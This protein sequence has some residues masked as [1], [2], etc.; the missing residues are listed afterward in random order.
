MVSK[1][2]RIFFTVNPLSTEGL[3]K[4]L[5]PSSS[6]CSVQQKERLYVFLH[7][8]L[9]LKFY[10]QLLTTQS[11]WTLPN[12]GPLLSEEERK[13]KKKKQRA[14]QGQRFHACLAFFVVMVSCCKCGTKWTWHMSP[15][16]LSKCLL[17]C[18]SSW[19]SSSIHTLF[20]LL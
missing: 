3:K 8:K 2:S 20:Q 9:K 7:I 12:R 11:D 10:L 5:V 16:M 13:R 4:I 1:I 15:G 6:D 14:K 18:I 19:H 17:R